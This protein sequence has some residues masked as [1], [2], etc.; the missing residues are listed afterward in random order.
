MIYYFH[1]RVLLF[2]GDAPSKVVGIY[3]LYFLA[4][5]DPQ[6]TSDLELKVLL[7]VCK[8]CPYPHFLVVNLFEIN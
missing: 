6:V 1:Q 3:V 7:K 5:F 4:K 8:L 2:F